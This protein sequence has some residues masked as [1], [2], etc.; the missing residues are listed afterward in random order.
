MTLFQFKN[1]NL[2]QIQFAQK[3]NPAYQTSAFRILRYLKGA[4][5]ICSKRDVSIHISQ[6]LL[7]MYILYYLYMYT[8]V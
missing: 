8:N 3:L 2:I 6:T 7:V 1:I 4:G 5:L